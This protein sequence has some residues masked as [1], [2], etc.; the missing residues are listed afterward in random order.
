MS[1]QSKVALSED[2]WFVLYVLLQSSDKCVCY[3]DLSLLLLHFIIHMSELHRN[4]HR[5]NPLLQCAGWFKLYTKA[6]T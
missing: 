6:E 5:R 4:T 2:S 3:L 1:N